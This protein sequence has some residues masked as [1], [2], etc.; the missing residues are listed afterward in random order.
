MFCHKCGTEIPDDSQFCRKCGQRLIVDASATAT[1]AAVASARQETKRQGTK[2]LVSTPFAIAGVLLLLVIISFQVYQFKAN[3]RANPSPNGA[4]PAPTS[5]SSSAPTAKTP[6]PH[7]ERRMTDLRKARSGE[8]T[9]WPSSMGVHTAPSSE[10]IP[11]F[12]STLS[13]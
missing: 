2:P 1:G 4:V 5:Q 7:D 12:P 8:R 11:P 9:P 6:V 3:Q 13:G 10:G